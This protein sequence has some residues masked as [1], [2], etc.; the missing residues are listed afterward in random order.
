[1]NTQEQ[2]EHKTTNRETM[3]ASLLHTLQ[4]RRW[5]PIGGTLV[6][7][8]IYLLL[9]AH[10]QIIPGWI[11][12]ALEIVLLSPLVYSAL[13]RR[14]LHHMATRVIT[15]IVLGLVTAMLASGVALLVITLPGNTHAQTLLQAAA[16]LWVTNVLVFSLWYWEIDGG[17]PLKRHLSGHKATDLMFP[18]Q[19]DGNTSG[20]VPLFFDYLFVAFTGA[21][22]L[23][24]T[25]TYPLTPRVKLLMMIEA[26]ISIA[27]IILL[28]GRAVNILS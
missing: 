18:Q 21:T 25:D 7:G 4:M 5:A 13:T 9:P 20:W 15:L 8:I 12:L 19:V 26:L 1:M 3:P 23:S 6:I 28:V 17:G 22:A 11:P 2:E 16:L 24:P 14:K 27:I 10:L